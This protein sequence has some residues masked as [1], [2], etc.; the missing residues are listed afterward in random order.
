ME[1]DHRSYAGTE[2]ANIAKIRL[3]RSWSRIPLKTEF[4]FSGTLK[5]YESKQLNNLDNRIILSRFFN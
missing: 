3:Q 1:K 4:I 2:I 5:V